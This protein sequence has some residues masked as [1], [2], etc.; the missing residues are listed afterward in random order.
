LRK[1]EDISQAVDIFNNNDQDSLIE[2]S[3]IIL[4]CVSYKP[5]N[6]KMIKN[7]L[8]DKG[9]ASEKARAISSG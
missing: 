3:D 6:E 4:L 1:K 8:I 2:G 7:E 5:E 9:R